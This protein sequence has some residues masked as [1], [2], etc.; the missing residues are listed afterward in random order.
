MDDVLLRM[1]AAARDF[2]GGDGKA[3]DILTKIAD[4]GTTAL[5]ADMAGLTLNDAHGGPKTVVFTD[6]MVPEIDEAQ[7]SADRGPCLDAS[8]D[9]NTYRIDGSDGDWARW[10]EFMQAA[11]SHGINSSLSLPVIV[12]RHPI[13]ALNFYSEQASHFDDAMAQMADGFAAQAAIVTAY[14]DKADL[15][16]HLQ[17]AMESRAAIEQAKGVIMATMGVGP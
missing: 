10:P 7:Y 11:R 13:G 16:E 14:C 4:L 9:G 12:A 8:R 2:I 5:G 1:V 3:D 17:T 15:A 6:R